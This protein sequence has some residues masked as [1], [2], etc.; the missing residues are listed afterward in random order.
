MCIVGTGLK[1]NYTARV[2]AST[3]Y[4]PGYKEDLFARC[5][6]NRLIVCQFTLT[7]SADSTWQIVV[8]SWMLSLKESTIMHHKSTIF[9]NFILPWRIWCTN[10]DFKSNVATCITSQCSHSMCTPDSLCFGMIAGQSKLGRLSRY[11]IFLQRLPNLLSELGRHWRNFNHIYD[12]SHLIFPSETWGCVDLT[13]IFITI[14]IKAWI[15][16]LPN[17]SSSTV[18]ALEGGSMGFHCLHVTSQT[19]THVLLLSY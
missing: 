19:L 5:H 4:P 10:I 8:D 1:L 17:L 7:I 6:Y 16:S 13:P 11:P 12:V 2:E 3:G 18:K 14:A 15:S 9:L